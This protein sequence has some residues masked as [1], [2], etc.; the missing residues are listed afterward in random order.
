MASKE[1]VKIN[2]VAITGRVGQEAKF[3]EAGKVEFCELSICVDKRGRK[4][5]GEWVNDPGFWLTVKLAFFEDDRRA[6]LKERLRSLGK[7]DLVFVEGTLSEESW[8]DKQSGQKRS[9]SIIE[10][11]NVQLVKSKNGDSGGSSSSDDDAPKTSTPKSI[12]QQHQNDDED[13]PF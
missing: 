1:F 9:K 13:I 11:T 10:A 7:G 4:V 2:L 8:E 5:N 12:Q 6:T 3:R